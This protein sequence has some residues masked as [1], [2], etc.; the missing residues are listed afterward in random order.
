MPR[1]SER[2]SAPHRS[3]FRHATQCLRLGFLLRRNRPRRARRSLAQRLRPLRL[4]SFGR[5]P[6]S[7]RCRAAAHL[8]L[9]FV[10]RLQH[11]RVAPANRATSPARQSRASRL[12]SAP[13]RWP[14]CCWPW[15]PSP[16]GPQCRLRPRHTPAAA[17][18]PAGGITATPIRRPLRRRLRSSRHQTRHLVVPR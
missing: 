2:R 14:S 6:A 15:P 9:P 12:A 1:H 16:P 10:R 7:P 3:H 17:E 18:S 5:I 11:P 13:A 4:R 8:A